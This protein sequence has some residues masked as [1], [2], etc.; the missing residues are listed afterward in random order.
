M[1]QVPKSQVMSFVLIPGAG[2][3]AWYWHRVA[4][5]LERAHQEAI[6]I[7][8]PGDDASAGLSDYVDIAVRAIGK[9]T[10]VTLVA[11]SIGGF[12]V[13]LVCA[14]AAVRQLVFVN[15][16]IPIPGET[17]GAWWDNTDAVPARIA[18]AR[19]GGY[20][21]EFDLHTYF[22]HDVPEAVLRDGPSHQ[23]EQAEGVFQEPCQ[24]HSWPKI[25][26][27]VVASAGDRFFPLEFQ[28]RVARARLDMDVEVIPGGHLVALSQPSELVARLLR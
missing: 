2:G 19:R 23:R 18:A 17:A 9:R 10:N 28:R 15:A 14:R 20:S 26:I 25:P 11:Q 5:L 1:W 21:T 3:M 13:P 27:R 6:T 24:F 16:M 7:D 12:T 4:P 8:L 22:L